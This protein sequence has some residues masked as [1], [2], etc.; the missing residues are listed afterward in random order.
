MPCSVVHASLLSHQKFCGR[1]PEEIK[2]LCGLVR[3]ISKIYKVSGKPSALFRF[4]L[5]S[6]YSFT[7]KVKLSDTMNIGYTSDISNLNI[8]EIWFKI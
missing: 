6:P 7:K 5:F 8:F 4:M 2:L 1:G 3:K